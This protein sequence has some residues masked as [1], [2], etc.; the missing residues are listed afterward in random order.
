MEEFI[1]QNQPNLNLETNPEISNIN[2]L[3]PI[4]L[5]LAVRDKT[6]M[7]SGPKGFPNEELLNIVKLDNTKLC[8]NIDQFE[9]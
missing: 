2:D 5:E 9:N 4:N 6:V 7:I 3:I 8:C 1:E